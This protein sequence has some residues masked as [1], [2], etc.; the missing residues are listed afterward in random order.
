[1]CWL[2]VAV[3]GIAKEEVPWYEFV[4]PLTSGEEGTALS[5]AKHFL[6]VWQWNIKV[7]GE[8]N[9]PPALTILNIG[10]FMTDKEMAG[11]M[12]EPHWFAAYSCTLQWV[13]EAACGR[14]W[15]WSWREAL[16]VRASPL[17]HTFWCKMGMDLTVASLKFCWE[18][19]PRALYCQRE[20]DPTAHIF[21]YLD[22]VA[23]CIP[24]LDT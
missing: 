6:T 18:P 21:T 15:E 12:G 5:L 14:K 7:H 22:N 20:S 24:S 10:Q 17:V 19:A 1:M 4:T 2:Q 8:D 13:G 3:Q 16:E 11:G 23:V 9:C